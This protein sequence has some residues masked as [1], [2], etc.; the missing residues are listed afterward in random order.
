MMP[1]QGHE[2]GKL[3]AHDKLLAQLRAEY[4]G[5]RI[6]W[7]PGGYA[8]DKPRSDVYIV[9]PTLEALA[10]KLAEGEAQ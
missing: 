8:A 4:P 2:A 1:G 6:G 3:I 10:V 5:L 7:A 9:A